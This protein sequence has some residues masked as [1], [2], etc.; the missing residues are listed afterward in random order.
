MARFCLFSGARGRRLALSAF[1]YRIA[2]AP[3]LAAGLLQCDNRRC[4]SKGKR[5]LIRR[6][7]RP[8]HGPGL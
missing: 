6:R 2:E 4:K 1:N 5:V 3:F 7:D 8:A